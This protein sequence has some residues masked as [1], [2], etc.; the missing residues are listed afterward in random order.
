MDTIKKRKPRRPRLQLFI[1]T[2]LVTLVLLCIV[3]YFLVLARVEGTWPE[4]TAWYIRLLKAVFVH[5]FFHLSAIVPSILLILVRSL[6]KDYKTGQWPKFL[7]GL[8]LR[9]LLPSL[10]ILLLLTSINRF[11]SSENFTYQWEA[12]VENNTD[13][14]RNHFAKDHKQRGIHAF[15]LSEDIG[16]LEILKRQNIE[17]ITLTPFIPQ[18]SY[19]TPSIYREFSRRDSTQYMQS[20]LNIKEESAKYGFKIHLKPHIWLM[21]RSNGKWRSDIAMKSPEDWQKWF[22]QYEN[23][24]LVYARL[25]AAMDADLFCIGTELHQTA[26]LKPES[27]KALIQKIKEIYDGPLTYAA[28]WN[29]EVDEIPFWEDMDY[30]GVQAYFPLA[31]RNNPSLARIERGWQPHIVHLK[32]LHEVYDLPILFTEMGYKS[33]SDAAIKPWAWNTAQNRLYK[34]IAHQAQVN[35]YQAFFNTI[36]QEEWLAGVHLWEW[37][38]RGQS[39]GQN[40][41]FSL[42]GKPALNVVAKSFGQLVAP[43]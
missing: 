26:V 7:K 31:D 2:Y 17:W 29:K 35:C 14:I 10:S 18:E 33:T 20:W 30:I 19:Q 27:W 42:E 40:N 37:Q 22:Q 8:S 6:V 13:T 39:D 43:E 9:I 3:A 24:M 32:G 16:D 28:N 41:A 23:Q 12:E 38:S 4:R 1:S 25:A 21:E 11:R 15:N 36:W 5:P 34:K